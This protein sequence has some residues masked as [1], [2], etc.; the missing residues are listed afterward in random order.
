MNKELEKSVILSELDFTEY[1]D[2]IELLEVADNYGLKLYEFEKEGS[3]E[4]AF[5]DEDAIHTL[6]PDFVPEEGKGYL[7]GE[8]K[9]L[10]HKP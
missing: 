1:D 10:Y 5:I 6:F 2:D 7:L 3:R 8:G 9:I 4:D